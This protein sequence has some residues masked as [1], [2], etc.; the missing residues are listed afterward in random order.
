MTPYYREMVSRDYSHPSV[1]MYSIGN[2]VSE[3][4]SSKGVQLGKEIIDLFHSLDSS[5]PVTGGINIMILSQSAKGNAVYDEEGGRDTSSEEKT[6]N[7]SSLMFNVVASMVGSGMNKAGNS[8]KA[9]AVSTPILD[10]LDVCGY[11]Y[12]SGRYPLEGKAH[13]ERLVY[14]SEIFPQD[15]AKNWALIRQYP[16]LVGD[17]L[18]SAWDYIG[19]CGAGAWSYAADGKGFEKPYPWKLA[20]V[21]ALDILGDPNGEM[22]WAQAGWG[23]LPGVRLT[24][25][26]L[27][28]P[29][30]K[31]AKAAW[32]GTNGLPG[33]SWENC[34]GNRAVVE[35][36]TAGTSAELFLNGKK[37]GKKKTK[38]GRAVFHTKYEPGEL[39]AVAYDASGAVLGEDVL[40]SAQG[41]LHLK[42][43]TADIETPEA[44]TTETI[45]VGISVCGENGVIERNHDVTLS[46][47]TEDCELLGFGSANPRTEEDF[48]SGVYTTYYGRALAVV[49]KKKGAT[50]ILTISETGAAGSLCG[51]SAAD[52][53]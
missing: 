3:P 38:D 31:I 4:A 1:I 40:I 34:E 11:N 48:S 32:R 50:A 7:M 36:F 21:G 2:E 20:D 6:K 49:R 13:P 41:K 37:I 47:V 23:T 28:H 45:A 35:A 5:R 33:W 19:E 42:C 30:A 27:N 17:F 14:G 43:D 9:D 29:G 51:S 44:Y 18:W 46:A 39:K 12:G 8:K 52:S 15:A 53:L 26:P 10:A 16:W 22:F 24:V 25:Q